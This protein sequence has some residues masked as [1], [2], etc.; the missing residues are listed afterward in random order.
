MINSFF[1]WTL[2]AKIRTTKSFGPQTLEINNQGL[3]YKDLM[4]VAL[5]GDGMVYNK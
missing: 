1:N 3:D 5:D 4:W 2:I